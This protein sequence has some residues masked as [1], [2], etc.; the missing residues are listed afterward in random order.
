[1]ITIKELNEDLIYETKF[2]KKTVGI[3]ERIEIEK[4]SPELLQES[5]IDLRSDVRRFL[6]NHLTVS[7]PL[8]TTL[9]QIA[10]M[11]DELEKELGKSTKY[12]DP[13]L[14][15]KVEQIM[16]ISSE[17][18]S[19]DDSPFP[20]LTDTIPV[21]LDRLHGNKER[22]E[23]IKK[24]FEKVIQRLTSVDTTL[25]LKCMKLAAAI[26]QSNNKAELRREVINK[27]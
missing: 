1:M 24:T 5:L 16:Q 23:L 11:S 14:K 18:S 19:K 10:V 25:R 27:I 4:D 17:I 15:K 3:F 22:I 9:A 6:V 8:A 2:V 13:S 26:M 12:K 7:F 21:L 20:R